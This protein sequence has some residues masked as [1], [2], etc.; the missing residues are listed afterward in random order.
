MSET[1]AGMSHLLKIDATPFKE[2]RDLLTQEGRQTESVQN[3]SIKAETREVPSEDDEW[4]SHE[5]TGKQIIT[6]IFD[7]LTFVS[8]AQGVRLLK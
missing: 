8:D 2:I 7:Q 6:I 5:S 1:T 4:E 3:V